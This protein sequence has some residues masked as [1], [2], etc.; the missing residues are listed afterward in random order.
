M[1][2][3][4]VR[5]EMAH[6]VLSCYNGVR[7]LQEGTGDVPTTTTKDEV[8]PS[9]RPAKPGSNTPA[10]AGVPGNCRNR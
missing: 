9:A 7:L 2:R 5:T 1:T 3:V 4:T 8:K 6:T 10:D